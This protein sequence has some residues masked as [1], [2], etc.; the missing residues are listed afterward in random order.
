[1]SEPIQA[2]ADALL[3]DVD[4]AFAEPARPAMWSKNVPAP[5]EVEAL[6]LDRAR[7]ADFLT[8]GHRLF[9]N[10]NSRQWE[11]ARKLP[12]GQKADG[13]EDYSYGQRSNEDERRATLDCYQWLQMYGPTLILLVDRGLLEGRIERAWR[14]E[15]PGR[16]PL[17]GDMTSS[18]VAVPGVA[19]QGSSVGAPEQETGVPQGR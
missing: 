6:L 8:H 5:G 17:I 18:G 1:M 19:Q 16:A 9:R 2:A 14:A 11:R 15:K 13:S 12:L 7:L 4:P 3:A 10:A